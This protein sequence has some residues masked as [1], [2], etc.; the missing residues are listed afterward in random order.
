LSN[1]TVQVL[2]VGTLKTEVSSANIIDSLVINHE[3]TIGVLKG[4]VCGEDRVVWFDN[5]GRGLRSWVHAELQLNLLSEV[6]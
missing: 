5:R 1:E 4:G 3:R 2:E 6:N